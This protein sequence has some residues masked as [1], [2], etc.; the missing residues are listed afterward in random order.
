M[1]GVPKGGRNFP[2]DDG[3]PIPE[4]R[5]PAK[6]ALADLE[7]GQCFLIPVG[8]PEEAWKIRSR[9]A[10]AVY[11]LEKKTAGQRQFTLRTTCDGVR[12]WRVA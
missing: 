5:R 4:R 3:A 12:V 1:M 9:L 10:N 7:V 2:I 11:L 6:Y 8:S